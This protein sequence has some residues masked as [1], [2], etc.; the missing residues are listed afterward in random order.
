MNPVSVDVP[1]F[2]QNGLKALVDFDVVI[3]LKISKI[4]GV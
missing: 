4:F 1:R 2:D 3:N